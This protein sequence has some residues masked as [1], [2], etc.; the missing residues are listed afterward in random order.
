MPAET[1]Q[2]RDDVTAGEIVDLLVAVLASST[3]RAEIGPD[4]PLVDLGADSELALFDLA[5]VVAEEYGE[6]TLGEIDLDELWS[7]RTVGA[8]AGAFARLWARED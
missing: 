7:E 1:H 8:L 3:D 5:D 6:R 4:T 2:Q